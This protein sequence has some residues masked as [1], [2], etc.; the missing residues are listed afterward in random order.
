MLS[1]SAKFKQLRHFGASVIVLALVGC[2]AMPGR[3][4]SSQTASSQ[5]LDHL[6]V[7]TPD[8]DHDLLAQLLVGEMA[9]TRTDLKDASAAYD[10]AM[11]LSNDPRVAERFKSVSG[12]RRGLAFR[13][14]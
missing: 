10:R 12:T 2:T 7:A 1:R 5:P 8:A 4:G 14:A 3:T 6:V 13:L 9:L 11:M